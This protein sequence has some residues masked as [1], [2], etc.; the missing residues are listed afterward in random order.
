ML[1]YNILFK[2]EIANFTKNIKKHFLPCGLFFVEGIITVKTF[3]FHTKDITVRFYIMKSKTKCVI[4]D[5]SE[6]EFI[7]KANSRAP[8]MTKEITVCSSYYS[9]GINKHPCVETMLQLNIDCS[10]LKLGII[11][12]AGFIMLLALCSLKRKR[13]SK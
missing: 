13:C 3:R 10:I 9:S 6:A 7:K 1:L 12:A 4:N 11:L 8:R 2:K 5:L